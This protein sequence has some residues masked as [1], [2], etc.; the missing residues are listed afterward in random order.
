MKKILILKDESIEE[1]LKRV[2]LG[3]SEKELKILEDLS[4]SMVEELML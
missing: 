4:V 1:C 3:L 2:E